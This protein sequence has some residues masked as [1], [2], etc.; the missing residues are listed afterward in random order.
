MPFDWRDGRLR[1]RPARGV[2]GV[3][4]LAHQLQRAGGVLQVDHLAAVAQLEAVQ[5]REGE[6]L[7]EQVVLLEALRVLGVAS[8]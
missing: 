5:A 1:G 6:A 4:Q 7:R 2:Y 8:W 3:L